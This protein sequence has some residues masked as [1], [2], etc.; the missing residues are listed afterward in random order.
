MYR[1]RAS[2]PHYP[3]EVALGVALWCISVGG[4]SVC[5]WTGVCRVPDKQGKGSAEP[6]RVSGSA[7]GVGGTD[8]GAVDLAPGFGRVIPHFGEA[9]EQTAHTQTAATMQC[10]HSSNDARSSYLHIEDV[11]RLQCCYRSSALPQVQCSTNAERAE[12]SVN[13][14]TVPIQ[15]K[16]VWGGELVRPA[17]SAQRTARP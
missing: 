3:S 6:S 5:V 12:F 17:S 4:C 1:L 14:H 10:Q 15:R 8:H 9:L 7:Q 13:T 11:V 16:C 2:T